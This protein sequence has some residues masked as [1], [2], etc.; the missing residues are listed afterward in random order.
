MHEI[1]KQ[2]KEE[3]EKYDT[4]RQ[5][6]EMLI[7]ELLTIENTKYHKIESR[8][9]IIESLEKKIVDKN[10]KYNIISDITDIIGLRIITYFEDDV[11]RVASIIEKEFIIDIENSI[12]K[13]ILE[14]NKFGYRSLHYV[15]NLNDHR[16]E[17]SEYKRFKNIK[18]EIQIRSI[19]Q[20]AWAEIEHDMGYKGIDTVPASFKRNF[21]MI[22]ALLEMADRDFINLKNKSE[23]YKKTVSDEIKNNP[24]YVDINIASL[25]SYLNSISITNIDE[26]I[27]SN[28]QSFLNDG[29]LHQLDLYTGILKY[30]Q[31]KTIEQLENYLGEKKSKIILFA[32]EWLKN[33]YKGIGILKGI[34]ILYLGYILVGNK[35]LP[36]IQEYTNTVKIG[37]DPISL[38]DKIK[39]TYD[40]LDTIK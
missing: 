21:S 26:E 17:L 18:F 31:I 28:A 15:V 30:F 20:H 2:Y 6:V 8:T 3:Y 4:F 10:N 9:K 32:N 29:G 22:A 7:R 25:R 12:D 38:A 14:T 5:K 40:S 23:E 24:E 11:D 33:D 36:K 39:K 16:Q 27:A 35:D 13:R 37:S 19:L 1:T 34:S